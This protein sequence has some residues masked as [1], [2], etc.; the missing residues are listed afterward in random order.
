MNA[1]RVM[2]YLAAAMLVTYDLVATWRGWPTI[3]ATVRVLDRESGSLLRWALVAL[4]CHWFLPLPWGG[5]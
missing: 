3:S 4:M 5:W 2:L 1:A